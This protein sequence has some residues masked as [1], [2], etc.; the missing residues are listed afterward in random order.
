MRKYFDLPYIMPIL[1]IIIFLMGASG[2]DN[3]IVPKPDIRKEFKNEKKTPE[4][5]GLKWK[6][7]W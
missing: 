2:C 4:Y 7:G 5:F 3:P 6:F 1:V